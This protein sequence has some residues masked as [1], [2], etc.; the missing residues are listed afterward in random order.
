MTLITLEG[1]TKGFNDRSLFED[2]SL[3]IGDGERVGLLGRNGSGKSTLL[4]ILAGLELPDEGTRVVKRGISL[5]YLEQEPDFEPTKTVR[6]IVREGLSAR[7][8]ILADLE[9]VH[10]QLAGAAEHATS[11]LLER[12]ARLE[13]Q[14]ERLGGYDVEHKVEST[15]SALDLPDFEAPCCKLSGG[16]RRRVALAQLLLGAPD[17]L[18]LDE[19]TNHLDAFV[20]DWLEDWFLETRTPLLLVTH[21]RY[22]LDRVVDRIVELDRGRLHAYV[23]GYGDYL[24][25]RAA[26]LERES[27]TESSRLLLLRR[28]TAWM[29]RGAPARTTKAKARIR[30]Y[31]D[32]VD[33]EPIPLSADLEFMIPPGPRLGARVVKLEGATKSYGDRTIVAP[34]DLEV[35][36]GT[37]LGVVGPNGAGK[38]TLVRMLLGDLE[39]D[40]GTREVGETVHF[41][42]IDQMRSELDLAAT[43]AY[44]VAG[45]Q[46]VVRVGDRTVRIE[47]F[48]DKFGFDVRAQGTNVAQLSGGE[49]NRVLFAKLLCAGGNVLVLDEPTN[50]LDLAT[51][52]ALEEALLTFP[53]AAILVSHDRWFLDRIATQILYLDGEGGARVHHG[54]LSD[55]MEVLARERAAEAETRSERKKPAPPKPA[56]PKES[57]PKRITPWQEKE[58]GEIETRI[59]EVEA[60]VAELDERQADPELY[61]G[62]R[63]VLDQVLAQRKELEEELARLYE[64]WEELESLR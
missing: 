10:A 43:V 13:E 6:E 60:G 52:R 27:K 54:D 45:N 16:E 15:M 9:D 36:P 4:S 51:L 58:L 62:P 39:L 11:A 28:E 32:L 42:G 8:G 47:S 3:A 26:R 57:K 20:T 48:L 1:V 2:L 14:L 5:G 12:Q 64:R 53:G 38:T 22:F 50:D 44:N 25:Q 23:G 19:P 34:L 56:P 55:L 59:P 24:E 46:G 21:D 37:R 29:R 33:A 31:D 61:T 35:M 49:Q 17:L 30:R 18:L 40:A 63:D 7:D 41:M